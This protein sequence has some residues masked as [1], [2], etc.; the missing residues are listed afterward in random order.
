[1]GYPIV[2]EYVEHENGSKGLEYRNQPGAMFAGA[3]RREFNL[4]L[5]AR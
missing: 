3:A 2:H 1:M 4:L 5:V